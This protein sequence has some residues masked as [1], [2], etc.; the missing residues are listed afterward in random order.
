MRESKTVV[1]VNSDPNAPIFQI[2]DVGV[3][4][5]VATVVPELADAFQR[6]LA[7]EGGV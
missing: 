7:A 5:D 4:G 1:A 3:V 6:G 2:A